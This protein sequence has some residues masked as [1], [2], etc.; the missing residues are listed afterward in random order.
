VFGVR[1]GGDYNVIADKLALRAGGYLETSAADP[2]YMNIDFAPTR[3]IGFG[4]GATYRFK[5]T[6]TRAFEL[7]AGFGHTFIASMTN[8]GPNGVFPLAGTDCFG[9]ATVNPNNTQQCTDG[10]QRYRYPFATNIGTVT[11][12]FSAINLGLSYRF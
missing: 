12:A 10:N 6:G 1:I 5:F 9:N 4:L 3:R 11:N 2:Q 8:P 7:S